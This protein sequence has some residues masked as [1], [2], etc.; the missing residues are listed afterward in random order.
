MGDAFDTE[1]ASHHW[2][3]WGNDRIVEFL[4]KQ[5]DMYKYIHDQSVRLMNEGYTG[6]ELSN[7]IE[8]PPELAREWY[9]RGCYGTVEHDTRAV[10]QRYMGFYDANPSTLDELP[11]VEAARKYV[12]YMGGSDAVVARALS[13]YDRGEWVAMALR[14]VVFADTDHLAARALLADAYEQLGYQAESGAWRSVYLQGAHELRHGR[15]SEGG[16]V[17]MSADVIG[18]MNPELLLDYLS[19][20]IDPEKAAGEPLVLNVRFTDLD[21]TYGLTVQNG[22]LVYLPRARA[23]ASA[24]V[25][26]AKAALDRIVLGH[27]TIEDATAAGDVRIEGRDDAFPRLIAMLDDFE[28]W[29]PI[30]TPGTAPTSAASR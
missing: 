1:F 10:Y 21:Q 20:R 9:N 12:E 2:P 14:H 6:V 5:R 23:E 3:M 28:F 17:T 7:L 13:D 18:A 22:V 29:F 15:P 24:T 26:L 8:L 16:T 4:R 11:P 25:S 19:V 30:V 27:T